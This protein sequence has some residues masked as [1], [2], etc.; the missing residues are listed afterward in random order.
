MQLETDNFTVTSAPTTMPITTPTTTPT[1]TSP[2]LLYSLD[3]TDGVE[4]DMVYHYSITAINEVG[5]AHTQQRTCC[6]CEV[7]PHRDMRH[8]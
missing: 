2:P 5:Q 1:S 4:E 7:H 3:E 6:K 8:C